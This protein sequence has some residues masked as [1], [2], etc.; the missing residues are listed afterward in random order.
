MKA[1]IVDDNAADRRLL[2]LIF[3]RRDWTV[4]EARDGQ[5]GLDLAIGNQPDIIVSDALMPGLDGFQFLRALNAEPEHCG[6]PFLFYSASYT[7]QQEN[8]LAMSLG[9]EAFLVKPMDPD[10]LWTE[11]DKIMT[12]RKNGANRR[13]RLESGGEEQFL[14]EYSLIVA[15]KLEEKVAELEKAL[16]RSEAAESEVRRLNA[17][18]EQRVLER[19]AAVATKG[20]ELEE[21]RQ[22]LLNLVEDLNRKAAELETA[23]KALS[24]EILQRQQDQKEIICLNEDLQRQKQALEA[25]NKELESFSYAV[26]HDLR[27]PLRHISSYA[28]LLFDEFGNALDPA[29]LHYLE[30]I[31]R[32]SSKMHELIDALLQ[33]SLLSRSDMDISS[34][35]L[36]DQVAEIAAALQQSEPARQVEFTIAAGV[37]VMADKSLMHVVLENLVGN[38]WKYSRQKEHARIE[39]GAVTEAG[40]TVCSVKDNGAGFDMTGK[41]RLFEAFQRLHADSE[42]EGSGIGLATVKR[43]I[44][45]HGGMV[46]AE[47]AVNAGATFY[48]T[49]DRTPGTGQQESL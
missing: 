28:G 34:V 23:N 15:A 1:L 29:A 17:E 3:Q 38:A 2:Q 24:Q 7:G 47:G 4:I 12:A 27:A 6:I 31:D 45:R 20:K 32:A 25:A 33:L 21:S 22:A 26:S 46:W 13:Q 18:L 19:T 43:I 30:R 8:E 42:F 35:N 49:L 41:N 14:R 36:S 37:C 5:E 39:F 16:L 11:I 10:L 44:D 9:A 48:F 40:R